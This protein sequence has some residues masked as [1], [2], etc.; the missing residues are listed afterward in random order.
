MKLVLFLILLTI[1]SRFECE[2]QKNKTTFKKLKLYSF[3][4]QDKNIIIGDSQSPYVDWGSDK[5]E[6]IS[7]NSGVNS[8]W[9]SGKTL[10]WLLDAVNNYKKDTSITNVAICIGTN[11]AFNKNDKIK[12]LVNSLS[13]KFPNSKLFVVQGSWGWGGLKNKTEK[14]VRDYYL[15]FKDLGVVV[16]EPPIGRI[17]PHGRKPVYKKIGS[18][19][20]SLVSL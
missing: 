11:G 7:K 13:V 5:F 20:D 18:Q 12:D 8:L 14:Q 6:L 16:I 9:Q 17:E 3:E 15:K 19:L 1:P 10:S 4:R 2:L